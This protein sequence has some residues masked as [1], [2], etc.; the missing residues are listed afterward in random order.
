MLIAAC[1]GTCQSRM[2][3]AQMEAFF[4]TKRLN[5]IGVKRSDVFVETFISRTN[6]L[7]PIDIIASL[8]GF[9]ESHELYPFLADCYRLEMGRIELHDAESFLNNSMHRE[10][11]FMVLDNLGDTYES[12]FVCNIPG[13]PSFSFTFPVTAAPLGESFLNNYCETAPIMSAE[14]SLEN[15]K[16]I[17]SYLSATQPRARLIFLPAP[18][19]VVGHIEDRY[20]RAIA[21]SDLLRTNPPK[22]LSHILELPQVPYEY[23]KLPDDLEH[24]DN[25]IYRGMAGRIFLSAIEKSPKP[26]TPAVDSELHRLEPG[27]S[28][29]PVRPVEFLNSALPIP[30]AQPRSGSLRQ[31]IADV[32]ELEQSLIHEYSGSMTTERWDSLNQMNIISAVERHFAVSFK[33]SEMTAADDVSKIRALLHA[34][35]ALTTD[36]PEARDLDI[37]SK[38]NIFSD[39]CRRS[40]SVGG[41]RYA[42]FIREDT[43]R[44]LTNQW[45]VARALGYASLLRD[46]PRQSVIAIVL[47]HDPDIYPSFIGCSIAGQIPTILAPMTPKQDLAAF[48]DS[49]KVLFERIK[50]AI[51]IT[52]VDAKASIPDF[53]GRVVLVDSVVPVPDD[54][55]PDL[56]DSLESTWDTK[57]IAF[58]QHSSGTTGHKKGVMLT[59]DQVA[60]QV[61]TYAK[62]IGLKSEDA[63]VTWLPLY[64]DMG[65]ITSFL[66]PTMLGIPIVSMGA[67]DWAS[68]PTLLLEHLELSPNSYCWLPNF[69]FHHIMRG[70]VAGRNWDLS[71]VKKLVSCS[72]PCRGETFN[73]FSERYVPHG[74]SDEALSVSYAMAENV[75]AVTQSKSGRPRECDFGTYGSYLSCGEPLSGVEV[76]IVPQSDEILEGHEIG[77]VLIKSPCLFDGYYK[78]PDILKDRMHGEFYA[79]GDLGSVVN[80]E[81]YVIG[82]TDD[83]LI[84]NGKNV[85]AHRLEDAVN[86]I[87]EVAAGR[88]LA[89]STFDRAQGSNILR[90]IVELREDNGNVDQISSKIRSKIYAV[91]TIYP[92]SVEFVPRGYLLKSTSGK[93]A[94]AAMVKKWAKDQLK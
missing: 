82:R 89:F 27:G 33:F 51:V 22:G 56:L 55:C 75:F 49:M 17:V 87:T 66:M 86:E 59:H 38:A 94:R 83:L 8:L 50:P 58:L 9:D 88:V 40:L 79:T 93:I 37:K 11:D 45:V 64:H 18:A 21:F 62:A 90:I 7:P 39:F 61:E 30:K 52:S 31:C 32:L 81:L 63:I 42:K 78:Q 70:D 36:T 44:T 43:E 77:E 12:K 68:R 53:D 76:K 24:F 48:Q 57:A 4:E 92:S 47:G 41:E 73:L 14:E 3:F 91:S 67:V 5:I 13:Y 74:L 16:I 19:W 26:L 69:A 80:G 35:G 20:S 54:D 25:F 29:L 23:T 46:I 15:W 60:W 1:I 85:L 2:P 84:I 34:K 71:R 10:F 72:E 65:L 6:I 28:N